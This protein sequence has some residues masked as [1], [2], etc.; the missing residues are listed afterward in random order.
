MEGGGT[1]GGGVE[2]KGGQVGGADTAAGA[3]AKEE[4]EADQQQQGLGPG[5]SITYREGWGGDWNDFY[6]LSSASLASSRGREVCVCVLFVY[7]C[8]MGG[9]DD[10]GVCVCVCRC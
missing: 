6:R 10:G 7:V 3:A 9:L 4:E 1:G 2:K 5:R 8:M